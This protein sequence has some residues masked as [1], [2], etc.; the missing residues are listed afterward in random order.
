MDMMQQGEC[1]GKGTALCVLC[2]DIQCLGGQDCP[3]LRCTHILVKL[4]HVLCITA[5]SAGI[6]RS[7]AVWHV[8]CAVRG[9][10]IYY[11]VILI[12]KI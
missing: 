2:Y 6:E 7:T 9:L 11:N 12:I 4:L 5:D 3:A 8:C 1:R 10:R